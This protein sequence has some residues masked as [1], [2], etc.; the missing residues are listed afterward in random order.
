V[1]IAY[2]PQAR[3][4]LEVRELAYRSNARARKLMA[5]VYRPLG[6]GLFPALLDLHGGAWNTKDRF[7]NEVMDRAIA[8]SGV[9]V[10]AIDLTLAP[11]ACYP[12]SVQDAHYGV[13]WLKSKAREWNGDPASVGILGSSTGGHLAEL[14]AMRPHD[15]RYGALA[16]PE[17]PELDATV[18]YVATR[19]PISD[20]YARYLHA[21]KMKREDMVQNTRSYFQPWETIHEANPQA[22][23]ERRE[24]LQLPP[25]LIMQGASDDNVLPVLQEKYAAAYRAAGG[26]CRLEIFEGCGHL[27]IDTPG[28]Q[29]ERAHAMVKHFIA[30]AL[31]DAP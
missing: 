8:E 2:D 29:T 26:D 24:K 14:V 11:E 19:S 10:V 4:E 9:L 16:L 25:L 18:R 27:W 5:R 3:F 30:H 7:A 20:P 21:E 15:A 12:A 31:R 6:R 17:A 28:V 23:L 1:R 13:R 22:M